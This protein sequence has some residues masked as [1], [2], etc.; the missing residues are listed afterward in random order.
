MVIKD[1]TIR[2]LKDG[3][4]GFELNGQTNSGCD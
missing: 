3:P 4:L 1:Q 2:G